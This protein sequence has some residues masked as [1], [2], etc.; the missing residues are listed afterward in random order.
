MG[1]FQ[2]AV[3]LVGV[4][5]VGRGDNHVLYL[6]SQGTEYG[7]RCSTCGGAGFLLD[8]C[9]VNGGYLTGKP[10]LHLGSQFG[11]GLGPGIA[12]GVALGH[13]FFEL[14]GTGGVEGLH[15]GEYLE[16]IFRVS[17]EVLDGVDIGFSAER[18]TVCGAVVF[19]AAAVGLAGTLTHDG[20][21]DDEGGLA[22]HLA[23]LIEGAA[24]LVG[25]VT[26]D[27]YNFPAPGFV[28]LGDIFAGYGACGSGELYVVGVV[29]HDEVVEPEVTCQTAG[30]LRNLFLHTAVGDVGIYRLVHHFAETG[31]EE[32]GGDGGTY[33]IG[34]TLPQRSRGVFDAAHDVHFGVSRCGASPLTEL[35]Q[36]FHGELAGEGQYRV[37][38]G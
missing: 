20:L 15:F 6:C 21:A 12:G 11:V 27:D 4:G 25:V 2:E 19:V 32:L 28:F 13:D 3:G 26:V 36:L 14:F 30:T 29:E 16:G 9:P 31:F 37:E 22:L 8:G 38:H 34:V 23:D 24:Y 33:G 1:L 5:E 18:G 17:A 7:G 35:A 10:A